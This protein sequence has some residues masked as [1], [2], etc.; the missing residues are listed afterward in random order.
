M[1]N[2]DNY[3]KA[4]DQ[5]HASEELKEKAFE[6]AKYAAKSKKYNVL[7]YLSTCAAIFILFFIGINSM[8]KVSNPIDTELAD[9]KEE[10]I[11]EI[12]IA[13]AELPRFESMEQ[14]KEV[15]KIDTNGYEGIYFDAAISKGTTSNL[16]SVEQS[17]STPAATLEKYCELFRESIEIQLMN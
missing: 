14:L 12:V 11:E 8:N 3:K 5:I 15:L 1:N 4:I 17:E 10:K 2:Q 13:N 6:N 16:E 9:K 7:K